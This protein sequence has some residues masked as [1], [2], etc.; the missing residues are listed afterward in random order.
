MK[1]FTSL[2]SMLLILCILLSMSAFAEDNTEWVDNPGADKIL[3]D[4]NQNTI[5]FIYDETDTELMEQWEAL[6]SFDDV[7]ED[8]EYQMYISYLTQIG[9]M[10]G[11]SATTFSPTDA[12]TKAELATT[13][14]LSENANASQGTAVGND[15]TSTAQATN[16]MVMS[17]DDPD[18]TVTHEEAVE[19]LSRLVQYDAE[20]TTGNTESATETMAT[21]TTATTV[22]TQK[23]IADT[24]ALS[25]LLDEETDAVIDAN[26]PLT[27]AEAAQ[28]MT[29]F[30]IYRDKPTL[31]T[32]TTPLTYI[33][34]SEAELANLSA[35]LDD[36]SFH[37]ELA[38]FAP[39]EGT[40]SPYWTS[41]GDINESVHMKLVNQGFYI[42]FSE[43]EST[44]S[45]IR[46]KY[47]QTALANIYSGSVA[48]DKDENDKVK[49]PNT[50]EE[51]ATY[52]GHYCSPD[53]RSKDGGKK[54]NAYTRFNDHY[55]DA[56][57]AYSSRN[58]LEA[59]T[60]LGKAIHYM[61]DITSPPHSALIPGDDHKDYENWV[62]KSFNY[63]YWENAT[64]TNTYSFMCNSEFGVISSSLATFSCGYANDC[65]GEKNEGT[66]RRNIGT[67]ACLKNCQRSVAGLGY[68]F[69]VDT[70]R[71]N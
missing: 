58:Y 18:A 29:G 34:V 23:K 69:L 70:G 39:E 1:K 24:L 21:E 3:V 53:L 52:I 51:K 10:D 11:T 68:R 57:V 41:G 19:I 67:R 27:R 66:E 14:A 16:Q 54:L 13:I 61:Q 47:S 8:Y 60:E 33:G 64:T 32:G 50:G 55:Y 7:P 5:T 2:L 56:K 65:V 42:L 20:Q 71:A 6:P 59:Y 62:K 17:V 4:A 37:A 22:F 35:A 12:I 40:V 26:K 38:G 9:V 49:D 28:M 46:G 63:S 15:M 36:E 43:K 25:G 30:L 48:P 45:N 44:V 31:I